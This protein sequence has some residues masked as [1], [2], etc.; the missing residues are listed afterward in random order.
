MTIQYFLNKLINKEDLSKSEAKVLL[1]LLTKEQALTSQIAA[2][3]TLLRSKGETV[4]E[5]T[6]FIEG[7]R[8]KMAKI[9]SADAI[10]VCGTGGDRSNSFNISTCVAFVTSGAGVKVAKHGNRAAS[11]KCGSADVL[12]ALGI[13]IQLSPKQAE[14][15]LEKIGMVFLFAPIYHNSFRNVSIVRKELG[16]KTIFNFLG[17]F[18]NPAGVKKQ[19]IGISEIQMAEKLAKVAVNLDYKHIVLVVGKDGFDEVS[20]DGKTTV[21]DIK[22]KKIKR[23]LFDP[24]EYGLE[25]IERERLTGGDVVKN[26]EI[27]KSVLSGKKGIYREIVVINSAFAFYVSE[28]AKDIKTGIEMAKRSIDSGS[29]EQLL[30][31]LIKETQKYAQ[32]D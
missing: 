21:F 4:K 1:D 18:V 23:Y 2:V 27:I 7:M 31:K 24:R 14:D 17:P 26:A 20:L 5:I 15:I 8:E 25:K 9:N 30:D 16:T 6:G 10:D 29:A 32:H 11:S 12:E 13:N 19:L 28:K 3:L 22:G